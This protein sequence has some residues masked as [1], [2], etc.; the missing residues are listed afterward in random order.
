[1]RYFYIVLV[2]L[3]GICG[4]LSAQS[5]LT[6]DVPYIIHVDAPQVSVDFTVTDSMGKTI[7]DLNQYDFEILDNGEPRKIQNFSPVKTPYHMLLLLDCSES[8]RD[9]LTLLV[10]TLARFADQLRPQDKIAI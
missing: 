2:I 9:R 5:Q 7:T 6:Q 8:V 3:F 1:M 4:T 10:I